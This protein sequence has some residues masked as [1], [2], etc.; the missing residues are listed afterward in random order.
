MQRQKQKPTRDRRK[1]TVWKHYGERRKG[2]L[3]SVYSDNTAGLQPSYTDARVLRPTSIM[4]HAT[5]NRRFT[6][7]DK[8][9]CTL[10][11]R[12]KIRDLCNAKQKKSSKREATVYSDAL[13]GPFYITV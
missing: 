8:T 9:M 12:K 7:E 10:T 4:T 1:Q 11:L 13:C 2:D 6:R 5:I 3:T